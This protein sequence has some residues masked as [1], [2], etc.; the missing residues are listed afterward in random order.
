MYA[1]SAK[2]FRT[3]LEELEKIEPEKLT[4]LQERQLTQYKSLVKTYDQM[5]ERMAKDGVEGIVKQLTS[6]LRIVNGIAVSDKDVFVATGEPVGYGYAVWRMGRDFKEPKEILTGMRGCCGQFDIQVQ[7]K[8]LLVAENTKHQFARYSRDGKALGSWGE[9]ALA[10]AEDKKGCFGGCCNPMNLTFCKGEI[11]TSESEGIIKRFSE[12][13]EFLGEVA[14]PGLSGGCKNVAVGA[15][16]DGKFVYLC[17]QP[18]S[19]IV[20]L[21]KQEA[22]EE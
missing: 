5:A 10:G 12:K 15:S 9:R 13:G 6:R 18:G 2:T 1:R 8:D 11:F 19:K 22:T 7:G 14:S 3:R 4:K 16:P 20:I 17:D 21:K